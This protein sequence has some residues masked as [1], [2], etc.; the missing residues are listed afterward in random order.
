MRIEL[1]F[2][3]KLLRHEIHANTFVLLL[4]GL[5]MPFSRCGP[6]QIFL[7]A[8]LSPG[9]A[10]ELPAQVGVLVAGTVLKSPDNNNELL[11]GMGVCR[12]AA[13]SSK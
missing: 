10:A 2:K 1:V 6:L 7:F 13:L 9:G 4:P 11:P 8:L 3:G 12:S 5:L